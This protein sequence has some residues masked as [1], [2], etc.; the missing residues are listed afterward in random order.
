MSVR[1]RF[2]PSPTG[3]P[4]VGNIRTAIFNWL[5]ARNQGGA[6]ILRIEDTDRDRY[7]PE[8]LKALFDGLKWLGL[9]W[10]EG[11]QAGGDYAPYFQSQRIEIYHHYAQKLVEEGWAYYCDCTEERLRQLREAQKDDSRE[12]GYD[13]HCRGRGIV[14]NPIDTDKVIRFKVPLSGTTRIN[15]YLRGT[16][17]FDNT[18]LDDFVLVKSDGFPTYHLANIVDDHLMKITHVMRGDEWISSSAKH[19]LLY[20][21]LGQKPPMFVHLPIILGPDKS[22]LSKRHGATSI[23]DYKSMGYLPEVMFNFLALLGWSPKDDREIMT[24]DELIESFNLEGINQ[25]ASVFDMTK[26]NWMNGEYIRALP[27]DRLAREILP[28]LIR[29]GF[30][31]EH[32][33]PYSQEYIRE[34]TRLMQERIKTLADLQEECPYFFNEPVE[35][36]EKGTQKHFL[37]E[38]TESLLELITGRLE[39]LSDFSGS[40]IEEVIRYTAEELG[41]GAGKIIHPLR[42]AISGMTK[43]PGL[44]EL[45]VTLGKDTVVRRLK[46]ARERIPDLMAK[47]KAYN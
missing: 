25:S 16:I 36:D 32:Y 1:L 2:A 14:G 5:F 41:I 24:R 15:D 35:Y 20:Q 33:R 23:L 29:Q 3:L 42:L 26:L 19:I 18:L 34:V 44:F 45:M 13:R 4:H 46:K 27:V 12:A 40:P 43:G 37:K 22:K 9:D 11:P 39:E 30:I 28:F 31:D 7:S 8:A 6:F 17:E 47:Y 38:G 10:D 21:A